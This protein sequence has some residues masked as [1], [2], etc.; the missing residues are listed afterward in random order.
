MKINTTAKSRKKLII[1]LAVVL[2]LAVGGYAAAASMNNLWPFADSNQTEENEP[3]AAEPEVSDINDTEEAA[4]ENPE[5]T[6]RSQ[7]SSS[8]EPSKQL[9]PGNTEDPDAKP[10]KPTISHA[11]Q[12]GDSIEVVAIFNTTANG[13]CR[14]TLSKT[15]AQTINRESPITVGPS[16]YIC[17]FTVEG[18]SGTGWTATV[19]H[20]NNNNVSDA[21]KQRVE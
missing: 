21:V 14:L 10:V 20:A 5:A 12:S 2:L 1:P 16:Y 18:V 3:Q 4:V 6:S 11:T 17:G 7:T 13:T 9:T 19:T 15:G 8:D